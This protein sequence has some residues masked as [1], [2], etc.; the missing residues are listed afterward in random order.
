MRRWRRIIGVEIIKV[1]R[2]YLLPIATALYA[3]GLTTFS[4]NA[5]TIL[6]QDKIWSVY[7]T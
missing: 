7:I 1:D 3:Y 6:D 5:P 4:V 2:D